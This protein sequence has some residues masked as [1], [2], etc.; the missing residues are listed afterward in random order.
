MDLDAAL[1]SVG[2]YR[3]AQS[4][5]MSNVDLQAPAGIY[6]PRIVVVDYKYSQTNSLST[7]GMQLVDSLPL[8]FA[9]T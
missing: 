3:Q 4:P 1:A 6:K 7:F 5:Y 2:H 8:Q 9:A